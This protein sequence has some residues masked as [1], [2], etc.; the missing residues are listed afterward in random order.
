MGGVVAAAGVGEQLRQETAAGVGAVDQ[1]M[2]RIDD[3]QIGVE[4]LLTT[5]GQ[6]V[7]AHRRV[8]RRRGVGIGGWHRIVLFWLGFGSETSRAPTPTLPR[9]RGRESGASAADGW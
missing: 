7:R 5:Q 9:W 3:R 2:V 1:V 8:R 4:D 6:P